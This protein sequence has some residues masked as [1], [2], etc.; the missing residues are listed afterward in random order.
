MSPDH[1]FSYTAEEA[2][3]GWVRNSR[4]AVCIERKPLTMI[5][6]SSSRLCLL[7]TGDIYEAKA[8]AFNY[9]SWQR[10]RTF[11]HWDSARSMAWLSVQRQGLQ[12]PGCRL[13]S[14]FLSLWGIADSDIISIMP[15][16]QAWRVKEQIS[17]TS[18]SRTGHRRW[19]VVEQRWQEFPEFCPKKKMY[20][21]FHIQK[22]PGSRMKCVYL[23]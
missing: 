14:Q 13:C 23:P 16:W 7:D 19:E 5:L 1:G 2:R 8:K 17:L 6:N 15:Q 21:G 3:L 20:V 18:L 10:V 11:W 12:G 22:E 4:E 9:S